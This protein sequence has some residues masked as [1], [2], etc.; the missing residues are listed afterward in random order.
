[1]ERRRRDSETRKEGW[2]GKDGR[3][4]ELSGEGLR[5]GLGCGE[6]SQSSGGPWMPTDH[7]F[8]ARGEEERGEIGRAHV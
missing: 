3:V 2:G 6:R 5:W 7:S 8:Q 4:R 1:M